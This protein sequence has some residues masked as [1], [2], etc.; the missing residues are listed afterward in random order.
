MQ[1]GIENTDSNN[2]FQ[3][4]TPFEIVKN[5][6]ILKKNKEKGIKIIF[7]PKGPGIFSAVL[8][9]KHSDGIIKCL[10]FSEGFYAD[11][12]LVKIDNQ[13]IIRKKFISFYL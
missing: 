9:I 13:P 5:S 7:K 3:N 11:I 10:I 8:N 4:Q 1:T 12:R 2:S 6:F